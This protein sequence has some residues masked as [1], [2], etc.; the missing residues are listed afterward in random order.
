MEAEKMGWN[1]QEYNTKVAEKVFGEPKLD[2]TQANYQNP[3]GTD[4]LNCKIKENWNLGEYQR[5]GLPQVIYEADRVHEKVHQNSCIRIGAGGEYAAKMSFPRHR[6][7][8][9]IKAYNA[10]IEL[11]E[12]WLRENSF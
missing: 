11:L 4:P 6:S 12:K 7:E 1:G 3:M 10:K 9:E 5:R 2:A 8:D